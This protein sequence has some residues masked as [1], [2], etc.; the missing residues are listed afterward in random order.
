MSR[1]VLSR[2]VA[3]ATLALCA[4]AACADEPAAAP[5]RAGMQVHVDPVTGALLD[6]AP[7]QAA[8]ASAAPHSPR[9]GKVDYTRMSSSIGTNGTVLIN[10]NGQMRMYSY[11]RVTADGHVDEECMSGTELAG[12]EHSGVEASAATASQE[13]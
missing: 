11:A 10:L 9:R 5:V 1:S 13:K 6:V 8:K 4:A 2:S 12:H 3:F 7:P